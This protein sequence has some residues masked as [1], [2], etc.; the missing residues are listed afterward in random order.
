[1]HDF[2]FKIFCLT[3]PIIS[4]GNTS[5]YQKISGSEKFYASEGY[6]TIF[7]RF[8]C[9]TEPKNLAGEPFC[10]VFQKISG[11]EKVYG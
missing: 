8:F 11:S 7:C 5:V 10:A 4:L 2:S 6:V 9:L 3:V 1:M